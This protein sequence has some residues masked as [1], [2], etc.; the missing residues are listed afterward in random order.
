MGSRA[1]ISCSRWGGSG[2]MSRGE[3]SRA[4]DCW[5][6]S[7]KN[8]SQKCCRGGCDGH[9]LPSW[10]ELTPPVPKL[11]STCLGGCGSALV[12]SSPELSSPV[13]A[14]LLSATHLQSSSRQKGLRGSLGTKHPSLV[15][16]SQNFP[17]S[18]NLE[19]PVAVETRG[20]SAHSW[21]CLPRG[22]DAP[23]AWVQFSSPDASFEL[24]SGISG[25][26]QRLGL[27]RAIMIQKLF[28]WGCRKGRLPG[29]PFSTQKAKVK[30]EKKGKS[31]F[32]GQFRYRSFL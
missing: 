6:C 1:L 30:K 15:P 31:Y 29:H 32:C 22:C 5:H 12:L 23:A 26:C 21:S 17:I 2:G 13:L 8:L 24:N 19:P 14:L 28:R 20:S 9:P 25:V 11:G 18:R 10:S 16:R 7:N 27:V 4:G 3:A